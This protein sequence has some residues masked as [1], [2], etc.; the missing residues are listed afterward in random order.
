MVTNSHEPQLSC[1]T[2]CLFLSLFSLPATSETSKVDLEASKY[3]RKA[4][5]VPWPCL[6]ARHHGTISQWPFGL[7]RTQLGSRK[8][9]RRKGAQS[10]VSCET[11]LCGRFVKQ[12]T[13]DA[14]ISAWRLT[15]P[16]AK[17]TGSQGVKRKYFL[18]FICFQS[19]KEKTD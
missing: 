9:G 1:N 8:Q 15:K 17:P 16:S 3:E 12:Q 10:K 2:L 14:K 5:T 6:P 13:P 4:T 7:S 11:S 18:Y 19:N